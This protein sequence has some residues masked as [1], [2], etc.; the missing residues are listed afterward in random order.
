MKV[1]RPGLPLSNNNLTIPNGPFL[2]T[3]LAPSL[4]PPLLQSSGYGQSD[5]QTSLANHLQQ[6]NALQMMQQQQQAATVAA[7][8][9]HHAA[10]A[11]HAQQEAV[12]EANELAFQQMLAVS[13]SAHM[14]P[15]SLY[16][17]VTAQSSTA[18]HDLGPVFQ[19][20]H[21]VNSSIPV[22]EPS[23]HQEVGNRQAR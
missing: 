18:N 14:P 21:R 6:L 9:Q 2:G 12:R 8:Q 3:T 11:A 17:H 20:Y 1:L 5:T 16:N 7:V 13:S 4:P 22:P 23:P 10:M 15:Q 19:K